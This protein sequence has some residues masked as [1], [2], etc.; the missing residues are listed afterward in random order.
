MLVLKLKHHIHACYKFITCL[1]L[2]YR[3]TSRPRLLTSRPTSRPGQLYFLAYV[4]E[5][6]GVQLGGHKTSCAGQALFSTPHGEKKMP[7]TP[8]GE[9]VGLL[10]NLQ[11]LGSLVGPLVGLGLA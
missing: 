11:H 7:P 3:P 4:F 2:A 8:T 1:G 10:L 5:A 6:E 9:P